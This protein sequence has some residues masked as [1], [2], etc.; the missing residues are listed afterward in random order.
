MRQRCKERLLKLAAFLK[1]VPEKHFNLSSFVSFDAGYDYLNAL[2]IKTKE[3]CI[4]NL[5]KVGKTLKENP[6]C[7]STACAVGWCPTVFP[8]SF[9]WD[10]N[11][12]VRLKNNLKKAN[13]SAAE[14]FF[15]LSYEDCEYL[16][17][18]DAYDNDRQGP[19]SVAYRIERFV[20][21]KS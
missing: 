12:T 7:G 6:I 19:K 13:F 9:I 14:E 8:R 4:N 17:T 18:P 1:T 10:V 2:Q 15:G 20:T 5:T 11:E 21:R 16:F 3:Q